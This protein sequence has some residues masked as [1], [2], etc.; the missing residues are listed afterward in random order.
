MV[1]VKK[2]GRKITQEQ[3]LNYRDALKKVKDHVPSDRYCSVNMTG[4]LHEFKLSSTYFMQAMYDCGYLTKKGERKGT[5]YK[6]IGGD[7]EITPKDGRNLADAVRYFNKQRRT[8]DK[9]VEVATK[10]T[11]AQRPVTSKAD[12][13]EL[14]ALKARLNRLEAKVNANDALINSLVEPIDD[15]KEH[16][17]EITKIMGESE[18]EY[19]SRTNILW[20]LVKIVKIKK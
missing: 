14:E 7:R 13:K 4:L 11:S 8:V 1:T 9:V 15:V 18:P 6:W 12:N 10:K 20:G 19:S 3:V 2:P 16:I 17:H 5:K